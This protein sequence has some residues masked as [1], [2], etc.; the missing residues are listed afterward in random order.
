MS[1]E[2]KLFIVRAILGKITGGTH[3]TIDHVGAR[4]AA[5]DI[6]SELTRTRPEAVGCGDVEKIADDMGKLR[7]WMV[8]GK[9]KLCDGRDDL[10]EVGATDTMEHCIAAI[11][12]LDDVIK[13][14]DRLR[15]L[16]GEGESDD[17]PL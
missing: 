16:A 4:L 3:G 7:R 12:T 11:A 17:G 15:S 6:L 5:D 13:E 2:L 1:E 9:K 14:V 8:D 10:R